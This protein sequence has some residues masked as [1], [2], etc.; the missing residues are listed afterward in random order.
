[1]GSNVDFKIKVVE[2]GGAFVCGEETALMASI[3]GKRG[4][5]WPR[6]PYPSES[7]LW[8]RPTL[9]NNV[10]TWATIP[11][12]INRGA[13]WFSS[14][15]SKESKG[16]KIFSLVGNVRNEGLIEVP[17]GTKLR[18]IVFEI[19]DGIPNNKELKAIQ[20]GGPSGGF[21]P[22]KYIDLPID[23]ERLKEK[24]SIMGSGGIVVM[25]EDTCIVGM[26]RH[27]MTFLTRESCGKCT[28]CKIGT[29]RDLELLTKITEGKGE[30]KD[31]DLL[32]ELGHLVR[33][34]ALCGFGWTA[35]SPG[36]SALRY[37]KDEYKE[38]I[39]QK[40]CRAGTCKAL[41]KGR[42]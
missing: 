27:F 11:R 22:K 14:I 1:M 23:Y 12:I 31:L 4:E 40:R 8:G 37:F 10:E 30:L 5:P 26:A 32:E 39:V 7:G 17:I 19:G 16:T 2:G 42:K 18:E 20:T 13:E 28:S 33:E 38:H 25:D 3:E 15:G 35:G 29:K 34:T 36:L 24:G 21:I 6:P 9:V 41:T